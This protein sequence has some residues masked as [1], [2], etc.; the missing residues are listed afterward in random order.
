[1]DQLTE[2]ML[3][4]A[5]IGGGVTGVGVALDA[6]SRGLRVALFEADDFAFG[7]SRWSSKLVHG[8]LRYL[9]NG[10][11]GVAWESAV[12]R[13]ILMRTVA[14]FLIR[15][16]AQVIPIMDDTRASRVAVTRAGLAAGDALRISAGTRRST[17]PGSRMLSAQ[18]TSH[19]LPALDHP[20]VRGGLLSWDG[21]LEDDARLVI[22][23]ARTAAAYGARMLT[24][25]RV[26]RTANGD[27][28]ILS[29]TSGASVT[30]RA[31]HVVNATGVWSGQFDPAITVTPSRGTHV[32]FPADRF[33]NPKAALTLPVPGMHARYCFALPRPDG[34]ILTGITDVPEPGPPEAVPQVP[35]DDIAWICA[36][37]SRALAHT[38]TPADAI[39]AFTGLRPLVQSTDDPSATSDLSR[40][41]L[42]HRADDR[43]WTITGGKLTTYRRMAQD[44]VDQ[45]TNE[46]CRTK[47]IPLIGA[48]PLRAAANVPA[49][50]LRRYGAE[51][52]RVAALA[53][54]RP[55]LLEPIAPGVAV[56]GVE[57]AF[58]ILA[59]GAASV[60]DLLERRTRVSLVP[61]TADAARD[62]VAAIAHDFGV[63]A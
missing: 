22:A 45:L 57:I 60:D 53:D 14:P 51:A 20:R 17:L 5:V 62:R 44:V 58:G 8:G 10:D 12:E 55:D 34:L 2:G 49:R 32:I 39:G 16:M 27:L 41:H 42:I 48:G 35:S 30:I 3:D 26:M 23:I 7:T 18:R 46:P 52:P 29:C 36:Q 43:T 25:T 59:E 15:P 40:R 13:N 38:V 54:A 61:H 33:G 4:V 24:R 21:S 37:I 11:I 56:R 19:L 1:M 47:H 63:P 31:H 50:L 28:E 6:A 9:A